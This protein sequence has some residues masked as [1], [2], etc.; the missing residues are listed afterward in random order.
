MAGMV[1]NIGPYQL[2]GELGRGAMARVWRAWDP[3]LQREVAI[4][5]PL[6]DSRL[7]ESVI[8]EMSRRFVGEARAAASLSHP[9]IVTIYAADVWDGRPAIVMEL[10]DGETVASRLRRGPMDPR[11]VLSSLDQ[12]LDAVGY[13]HGHGVVHRDIKPDNIFITRFGQVKLG[14]FGIARMDDSMAT[15]GT[16]AGTVLG[17]PGYMSPE[18]ATGS[19]V[20]AR[21]DLF[22]VGA[23]GYEMLTGR[24]PFGAGEGAD[25]ITLIYRIVHEPVPELPSS[26]A[27]GLPADLR[28]AI[29]AALSKDP[30]NRPQSAQ[31]FQAMLHGQARTPGSYVAGNTG[32]NNATTKKLFKVDSSGN[33]SFGS[34]SVQVWSGSGYGM[35]QQSYGSGAS[36]VYG[37][38][39]GQGQ[40]IR[41]VPSWLP[42]AAVAGVAVVALGFVLASALGGG[43]G[44]GSS[45]VTPAQPVAPAEQQPSEQSNEESSSSMFG[46]TE[47][48]YYLGVYNGR[49]AIFSNSMATPYEVS[50]VEVTYLSEESARALDSHV[51]A[52]SLDEAYTLVELYRDEANYKREEQERIEGENQRQR[53]I[54]TNPFAISYVDASSYLSSVGQ[55]SHYEPE[56]VLDDDYT[57]AWNEGMESTDGIGEWLCVHAGSPSWTNGI[58]LVNGYPKSEEIYYKNNR[59][60]EVLIEL[61]DGYSMTVTLDDSYRDWQT[62]YFDDYHKTSYIRITV[63]SVYSGN[64]WKDTAICEVRVL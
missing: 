20:D 13:A 7:S 48:M 51:A 22:S 2:Q 49:V 8:D 55:A 18:Q 27:A 58:R 15:V 53:E 40:G 42:Y 36:Q 64:E 16:V 44:G 6:F 5:E 32:F 50:D 19:P 57:T 30:A 26:A 23:V 35:Q 11:E 29:M 28:P 37:Q 63:V 1:D 3:N 54:E 43:G 10:I 31:E 25:P 4:K 52:D 59:C 45:Y 39:Q 34:G 14:D 12:L 21:S 9:G 33:A 60:R 24:N 62:I 41:G 47:A 61:S 46:Q 56:L 38:G 17:T